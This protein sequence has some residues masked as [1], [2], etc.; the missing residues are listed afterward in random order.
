MGRRIEKCRLSRKEEPYHK[1]EYPAGNSESP[2]L[3]ISGFSHA[4]NLGNRESFCW[5]AWRG[6]F[7]DWHR[8]SGGAANP[9]PEW[10]DFS[11][12]LNGLVGFLQQPVHPAQD[13]SQTVQFILCPY[14]DIRLNDIQSSEPARFN[15]LK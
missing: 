9:A 7:E 12:R 1:L 13:F 5:A 14:Q 4:Q 10:P 15:G 8:R 11:V 6:D 3:F 2:R